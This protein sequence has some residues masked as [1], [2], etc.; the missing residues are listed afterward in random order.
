[1]TG[2]HVALGVVLVT[3]NL[4]AGLYGGYRWWRGEPSRAFWILL[5]AGQVVV[6]VV[7]AQ[8]GLLVLAGEALPQLHLV[9]GLVPVAVSFVAEQLR[10]ASAETVLEAYDLEDARAVGGLPEAEQREVV[11]AI[12]RREMGV[13]VVSALVITALALRAWT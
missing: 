1:M 13:M 9:Y 12:L 11:L 10:V 8:G 5:R 3:L 4:L 7:A 2:L 6:I